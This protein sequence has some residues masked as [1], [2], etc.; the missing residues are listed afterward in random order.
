MIIILCNLHRTIR[1]Q[2]IKIA[3]CVCAM[4][5][6]RINNVALLSFEKLQRYIRTEYVYRKFSF[7]VEIATLQFRGRVHLD[8]YVCVV[9]SSSIEA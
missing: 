1:K 3:D 4:Y 6:G 2:M 8:R 9:G 5:I 7:R